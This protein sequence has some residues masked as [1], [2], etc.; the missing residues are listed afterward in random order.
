[1]RHVRCGRVA[2]AATEER[3][4]IVRVQSRQYRA[5]KLSAL[6][7]WVDGT[8]LS[9]AASVL[10]SFVERIQKANAWVQW[11]E[12]ALQQ[13]ADDH[14]HLPARDPFCPQRSPTGAVVPCRAL[15]TASAPLRSR[16]SPTASCC[17]PPSMA[18][19]SLSNTTA[20]RPPLPPSCRWRISAGW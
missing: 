3:Q 5:L 20:T 13:R 4:R 12:A 2:Q 11:M 17:Q 8:R 9:Q 16:P 15:S 1:M 6:S 7:V 14:F 18:G 19:E 10:S